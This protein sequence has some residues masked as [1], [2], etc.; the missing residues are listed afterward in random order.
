MFL[1][2]NLLY[3]ILYLISKAMSRQEVSIIAYH[4]VD[5]NNSFY[6]VS[7]KEFR[8]QIEYLRKNYEV[9]SLDKIV[10]FVTGKKNLPKKSVAITFDDGYY[11]NYLNVYPYLKKFGLPATLFVTIG[12][13]GKNIPLGNIP[14]KM[15]GWNEIKE[16]SQN[17]IDVGAHAI[18]HPNLQVT[19]LQEAKNEVLKSKEEIEKKIGRSIDYFA[20]PFSRCNAEIIDLVESYGFKGAVDGDGLIRLGDDPFLLN[21]VSVDR[22]V[23]FLMFKARLTKAVEWYKKIEQKAKELLKKSPFMSTVSAMYKT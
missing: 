13:I 22:S 18:S 20:Y 2:K 6:T 19:D 7:P 15:L 21:R 4:S 17:N 23:N 3:F 14:L 9:V 16:M 10:D 11:D 1:L 5:W 12:Y 8:R